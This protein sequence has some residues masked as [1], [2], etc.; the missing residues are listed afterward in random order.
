MTC[1]PTIFEKAIG[2]GTDYDEQL[3]AQLGSNPRRDA[4]RSLRGTRARRHPAGLRRIPAAVRFD[5]RQR[6]LRQPRGLAAACARHR[7]HDRGRKALVDGGRPAQRDD[8]NSRRRPNASR[9]SLTCIAAGININ[10]TLIFSVEMYEA[11]AVAYIEGLE[12]RSAAGKPIERIG[13]VASVFVSRIDS[14]V[15]ALL[16]ARI[17][18]PVAAARLLGK[19]G[20]ANVKL[21]YQKLQAPLRRRALRGAA[22]EGRAGPAP[23]LGQHRYEEPRLPRADVR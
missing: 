12:A 10:V 9:R 14:A 22:R 5:G 2:S 17:D 11:A 23:A 8:Q 7:R 21:I 19:A 16:Q 3:R 4:E 13:S 20:V 1:N 18:R 15:D 6:R